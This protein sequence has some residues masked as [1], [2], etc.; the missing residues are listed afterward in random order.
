MPNPFIN[1]NQYTD[2]GTGKKPEQPKTPKTNLPPVYGSTGKTGTDLGVYGTNNTIKTTNLKKDSIKNDLIDSYNAWEDRKNK[3]TQADAETIMENEAAERQTR[4][5]ANP[6]YEWDLYEFTN[7]AT[8][9]KYSGIDYKS[10]V[11]DYHHSIDDLVNSLSLLEAQYKKDGDEQKYRT[12][13]EE[14]LSK[15]EEIRKNAEYLSGFEAGYNMSAESEYE[16]NKARMKEITSL[17]NELNSS[18]KTV[19]GIVDPAVEEQKNILNGEYFNLKTRNEEL[20]PLVKDINSLIEASGYNYYKENGDDESLNRMAEFIAAKDNGTLENLWLDTEGSVIGMLSGV[21][22]LYESAKDLLGEAGGLA[23]QGVANNLKENGSLSEESFNTLIELAKQMEDY[24]FAGDDTINAQL[25]D[26]SMRM[27]SLAA[28]NPDR[29]EFE[30]YASQAISGAMENFIRNELMGKKGVLVM[31]AAEFASSYR[32]NIDLGYTPRTAFLNAIAKG[33]IEVWSEY[34]K[35]EDYFKIMGSTAGQNIDKVFF[36]TLAQNLIAAVPEEGVEEAAAYIADYLVDSITNEFEPGVS[37]PEFKTGDMLRGS[38]VAMASA[39]ISGIFGAISGT[40]NNIIPEIKTVAEYNQAKVELNY[41]IEIRDTEADLDYKMALNEYI[42][43]ANQRLAEFESKS[44]VRDAVQFESDMPTEINQEQADALYKEAILPDAMNTANEQE[45]KMDEAGEAVQEIRNLIEQGLAQRG[46]NLTDINEY[47]EADEKTRKEMLENAKWFK[48]NNKKSLFKKMEL[49]RNGVEINGLTIINTDQTATLDIDALA[50]L[51]D[52]AAYDAINNKDKDAIFKKAG[53]NASMIATVVHEVLHTLRET[54]QYKQILQLVKQ[55]MGE[56][57]F[58]S[59]TDR[60]KTIYE[61]DDESTTDAEEEVVAFYMQKYL[62]NPVFLNKLTKYNNSIINRALTNLTSVFKND[63]AS[64]IQQAYMQAFR[65]TSDRLE[66]VGTPASSI[67]STFQAINMEIRKNGDRVEAYLNGERV[68]EVTLDDVKNSS[69][70]NLMSLGVEKGFISQEESDSQMQMYADMCNLILNTND[71]DLVWAITGSIGYK[72]V[73]DNEVLDETIPAKSSALTGNADKQYKRTFDVT[74]ICNKTQ[75]V[76]NVM[77]EAMVKLKRGLTEDE[78]IKIVYDEV[79]KEGEPVPCPVCYVFSR[80]VGSGGL[81]ENINQF[82]KEYADVDV[83]ELK[84][85][86]NDLS[87]QVDAIAKR[88]GIRGTDARDIVTEQLTE[89]YN[90]LVSLQEVKKLTNSNLSEKQT[91]RLNDLKEDMK[92]MD[93]WSWIGKTRLDPNYKPVPPEV[94]FDLNKGEQFASDYPETWKYRTTRGPSMGKAITPYTSEVLGQTVMGYAS[95]N[96]KNLGNKRSEKNNAFLKDT[97]TNTMKRYWNRAISNARVQNLLGGARAQSTSDFRFEYALDYMLYFLELQSI[98]SYGQTYT[99][100]PEAVPMFASVGYETNLSLMPKGFGYKEVKKGTEGAIELNG[101]YYALEFSSETG[102]NAND[103]FKLSSMYDNVQPIIVGINDEH[104]LLCMKDDRITFIIPYHSS[105]S[106]EQRYMDMMGIVGEAVPAEARKD[107]SK[108][109][110]DVLREDATPTQLELRKIRMDILTGKGNSLSRAEMKKVREHEILSNLYDRFYIDGTDPDCYRAFLPKDQAEMIFPFEYWDKSSTIETADVNGQRFVQY[111]NDLGIIPRFE[112]FSNEQGYWKLLIDRSMY[113]L[114]GTYHQQQ[115]INMS[116]FSTDFLKRN[117]MLEGVVQ[118]DGEMYNWEQ[119]SRQFDRTKT[120]EITNNVV[121][122]INK[123]KYSLGALGNGITDI[124]DYSYYTNSNLESL[125]DLDISKTY[126]KSTTNLIR[127]NYNQIPSYFAR[128]LNN[129]K[130][131]GCTDYGSN[132]KWFN[133]VI[134]QTGELVK[135]DDVVVREAKAHYG[136]TYTA[137][138]L[139]NI[140]PLLSAA[141]LINQTTDGN[142]DYKLYFNFAKIG[143]ENDI[144]RFITKNKKVVYADSLL[145]AVRTTKEN[146]SGSTNGATSVTG[147]TITISRLLDGIKNSNYVSDLPW[148]VQMQLNGYITPRNDGYTNKYSKGASNKEIESDL[149]ISEDDLPVSKVTPAKKD[150]TETAKILTESPKEESLKDVFK[151]AMTQAKRYTV[152]RY[153]AVDEIADKLNKP[154]LTHLVDAVERAPARANTAIYNGL[155]SEDGKTKIGKSLTEILG[156]VSKENRPL[157]DELMYHY[158]NIDEMSMVERFGDEFKDKPVFGESVTADDSRERVQ[159]IESQHPEF[160]EIAEDMW[161]FNRQLL[162]M[163]VDAGIISQDT[164]DDFIEKRPHYVKIVRNVQGGSGASSLNPNDIKKFKGSTQDILPLEDAMR[165][166]I[167]ST[168]N[169]TANNALNN[170]LLDTLGNPEGE[171]GEDIETLIDEGYSPIGEDPRGNRLY[172]YRDGAKY[173]IPISKELHDAL[174]PA[175]D[176]DNALRKVADK[177]LAPLSRMRKSLLT[178]W[179]PLFSL[180]SNPMKD[181]QDAFGNTKYAKSYLKNLGKAAHD[182][183]INGEYS[184]QYDNLGIRSSQYVG[185]DV[186]EAFKKIENDKG[187]RKFLNN[188]T[189]LGENIEKVP[190]LAEF[191]SAIQ[192]G[193]SVEEAAYDAA[194]ITTNFKRGGTAVK[195]MDKYGFSFLNASVQGFDKQVRNAK[196]DINKIRQNGLKGVATV[197]A[198]LTLASGIPLRMLLDW[199]WRDDK[200]YEELSDYIKNNYYIIGKRNGRFIRIPKGRVAAFYQTVLTNAYKSVKGQVNAWDAMLDDLVSFENNIAPNNFMDNN[201]LSPITQVANGKTWYGSDLIPTRLQDLPDSEQYDETTDA[202]SIKIGELSKK[203]AD[204]TGSDLFELSPY[205]L[206]YLLDQYTGF[207]G[208]VALPALSLKTEVPIDNPIGKGI[209]TSVLDKF[210]TDPVLKNQ[211]V[212]SFYALKEGLDKRANGSRATDEEKLSSKYLGTVSSEMGKLYGEKREI[213]LDSTLSNSEK[214]AKTREIQK[215]INDLAREGLANY[216]NID[217]TGSYAS[218]G[219][220]QYYQK[221]DGSWTKPTKNQLE[222][223]ND[224]SDD[225]KGKYFDTIGSINDI[226]DE[227]KKNTPEGKDADYTD[228][229]LK[230][231]DDSGLSAKGKN[232]LFDSYYDSKFV[233]HVN[234][235]GLS[236]EDSYALKVANKTAQGEKDEN[237]KTIANSKARATAEKYEELGL[238]DEVLQYIQDNDIAPSEMGLSKT[239]YAE[240]MGGTSYSSVY[241]KNM[242]K[243]KSSGKSSK[244][245]TPR[246]ITSKTSNTKIPSTKIGTSSKVQTSN[247]FI[248]AY[249]STLS[250]AKKPQTGG[251]VAKVCPNCGNRVSSVNG[252]CPVCGANL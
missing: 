248:K 2:T 220:V 39:G 152:D 62:G 102:M 201:L 63:T 185:K 127:M 191:I 53:A 136:N 118:P 162:K 59:A 9:E 131:A 173:S 141:R 13:Y 234:S 235:M 97:I 143:T 99:K 145:H 169:V 225:D 198:R 86:Y 124:N 106:T 23:V 105:G 148:E 153:A 33:G 215:Q 245:S 4:I 233:S 109:Q 55:S 247:K 147:S 239:V 227:I 66:L 194:E 199:V 160:K 187:M 76:I 140:Y 37:V 25:H 16:T 230:A 135:V 34:L 111:C 216:D 90:K 193:K 21:A 12:G 82:Q 236:D 252:R 205:K 41:L 129:A 113:N 164:Y 223:V 15:Q 116:N 60:I 174:A 114:D 91:K 226:R 155:Y 79:Y 240:L 54:G 224:L 67:G 229:T 18:Y 27:H 85:R 200:D 46:V 75:Q 47:L 110:T 72:Q 122:R 78:I 192:N 182:I 170:E 168:Y 115:A 207:I 107:Y 51:D 61:M 219:G 77:S 218:I 44:Q 69:L 151:K 188:L 11:D 183:A 132:G 119:P 8:G 228:A 184:Q 211:N 246:K 22:S 38:M 52:K 180:F 28:A 137:T 96:L 138:V 212:T 213:Q 10:R 244:K 125:E 17:L 70:G 43:A 165:R 117:K 65:N 36:S 161:E 157:F 121:D 203:V 83:E 196:G 210:T 45:R 130:K 142:D 1:Q 217:I 179:N 221:D 250:G 101:K 84:K 3:K 74:T 29:S 42:N 104:I 214:Y 123:K 186:A 209:A 14:L 163:R 195:A 150:F 26:Y 181:I 133:V 242:K 175:R 251:N 243:K 73:G 176:Y 112:K 232:T 80:W 144:V 7:N 68:G 222:K 167:L 171:V 238:L 30:T 89:E 19:D 128:L 94:L 108:I 190:R 156:K 172:A 197:M 81:L 202:L 120:E 56:D 146:P 88:E 231:I 134:E 126:T 206:N 40:R 50:D 154:R 71:P 57:R 98:N 92:I 32:E 189:E 58:K 5:D 139:E 159:E 87:K 24:S 204:A 49:G 166:H 35:T 208:D 6:N 95:Q 241:S 48:D 158:R 93:R 249:A 149:S 20:D 31:G 103:A 64:K 237:G 100:V 178:N 177:T